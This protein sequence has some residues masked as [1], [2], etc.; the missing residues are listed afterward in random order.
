MVKFISDLVRKKLRKPDEKEPTS[1]TP[2]KLVAQPKKA[3]DPPPPRQRSSRKPAAKKTE[4]AKESG[5][6]SS[7]PPRKRR[8][9]KPAG[10]RTENESKQEQP[11]EK[12]DSS[13]ESNEQAPVG[14]DGQPRRRRRRRPR[15]RRPADGETQSTESTESSEEEEDFTHEAP[16]EE[17]PA[18]PWDPASFA[19]EPEEGKSRFHDLDLPEEIMHAVADLGFQY[20]TPIQA[21]SMPIT[22]K[23]DDVVG[24]A[25]TGTGKSAAF[26]ITVF[27]RFLRNPPDPKRRMGTPRALVI[28]PTR[29]LALQIE[30][31][32]QDL[33]KYSGLK[34]VAVFG[35]MD[36]ERQRRKVAD[37]HIDLVIATPGRLLDF[38][39]RRDIHLSHVEIMII[40]EADRMLD[41]GFIPDVRNIIHSTPPK[42][43]R[44]TMFFSATLN[45]DVY[46]LANL[47]T[48]EAKRIEI[49]PE[50][51]AVDTVD[52]KVYIV[53]TQEKFALLLNIIKKEHA[54]RVMVFANRRDQTRKLADLL[55]RYNISCAMLSGDVPQNKRIRTLERFREG[56]VRVLVATDVAGRGI[57]VDGVSHVVNFTLPQDA[58]D[59]VHRI[60]RTGRAGASGISISFA[61]EEDAFQIPLIEEFIGRELPGIVPD[62][63][64]VELPPKPQQTEEQRA[65][66]PS[67]DGRDSRKDGNRGGG[68]RSGGGGRRGGGGGGGR[69]RS[70]GGG[71]GRSSR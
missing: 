47:W 57:H 44:Q 5:E 69:G 38:K 53:T 39:R 31:D 41:M 51:V 6:K 68:G 27:D 71:R 18:E 4:G 58:E 21:E 43:Q 37:Q 50:Q 30:K 8:P 40:D 11:A 48:R 1:S 61:C 19:V 23:G 28:A 17:A 66:N 12:P 10:E 13:G 65:A 25:Q 32:A 20:C 15:R 2:V 52:Q 35:G 62:D 70:S 60:G 33:G 64:M 54:E 45:A 55:H 14:E 29:E 67:H 59:Y 49:Q 42:T 26:L 7:R 56:K 3:E 34:M 46:K 22:L 9:R 63:D 36:Y 16:V 24:K